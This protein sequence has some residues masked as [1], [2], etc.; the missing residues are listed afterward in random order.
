MVL[1]AA[2]K[3]QKKFIL[4]NVLDWCLVEM[5]FGKWKILLI[6]LISNLIS[7]IS[8]SALLLSFR[9]LNCLICPRMWYRCCSILCFCLHCSVRFLM[10]SCTIEYRTMKTCM[11]IGQHSRWAE[12]QS[13]WGNCT[14]VEIEFVPYAQIQSKIESITR[15]DVY[16]SESYSLNRQNPHSFII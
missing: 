15:N 16:R 10:V 8:H 13:I 1:Q 9:R 3:R 5:V 2:E 12:H 14:L 7:C 4:K 11:W 6:S